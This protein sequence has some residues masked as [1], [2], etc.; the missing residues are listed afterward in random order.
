[1]N[2]AAIFEDI[3]THRKGDMDK[4]QKRTENAIG[5]TY[6]DIK[7]INGNPGDPAVFAFCSLFSM[8]CSQF[9]PA[10]WTLLE[11]ALKDVRNQAKADR[12]THRI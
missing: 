3:V 4:R 8:Q 2:A 6:E 7:Y 11:E 10:G 12:V 1:V 9:D 5:L